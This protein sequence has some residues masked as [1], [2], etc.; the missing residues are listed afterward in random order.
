M[1]NADH[2]AMLQ[3]GMT[4]WN[5]WRRQH[6]RGARRIMPN[7]SGAN[8]S[9]MKLR[10]YDLSHVNFWAARLRRADLSRANLYAAQMREADLTGANLNQAQIKFAVLSRVDL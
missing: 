1:A 5:Q 9:G 6:S 7:L 3:T 8:L 10:G 4:A 2:L